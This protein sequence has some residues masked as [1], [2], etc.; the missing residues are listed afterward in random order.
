MRKI[1]VIAVVAVLLTISIAGGLILMRPSSN[2]WSGSDLVSPS[3]GVIEHPSNSI[4]GPITL[5]PRE[6]QFTLSWLVSGVY[7]TYGGVARV[8]MNNTG[9]SPIFVYEVSLGWTDTNM[10]CSRPAA[11]L[12][13]P[14][15]EVEI[16]LLSFAAPSSTG[17]LQYSIDLKL[18]VEHPNGDWYDCGSTP[19]ASHEAWVLAPSSPINFTVYDNS[20]QYYNRVNGLVDFSVT[21]PI[22]QEVEDRFPG[23]YS[24]IQ[25]VDCY[26]WVRRN[27]EY[28]ADGEDYWQSA[29]ETLSNRTGD[30]EDQAILLASLIG[31]I[32]GN[33]KVNIIEG[34][35]FPTVFVGNASM[36]PSVRASIASYYWVGAAALHLTYLTDENGIWLVID[37]VGT[38]F[39]GGLPSLSAP[40]SSSSWGDNWTFESA[41]WCHEIDATGKTN[42]GWL[43]F[44]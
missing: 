44:L 39:A 3:A 40:S 16:G 32:G 17:H 6:P 1:L 4:P 37:P 42:G 30:C 2:G 20:R 10:S 26:E 13:Q 8:S 34:H 28:L 43:P 14:D 25:V 11:A 24:V 5:I 12:V 7:A 9:S 19:I 22:A 36:L 33:A 29:N 27:I 38:Q 21:A 23:A 41:N 31:E 35:A 15:E 18:A